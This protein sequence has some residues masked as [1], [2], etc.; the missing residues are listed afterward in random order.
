MASRVGCSCIDHAD[1]AGAL[2]AR[3]HSRRA[4]APMA[5]PIVGGVAEGI[6]RALAHPSSRIRWSRAGPSTWSRVR[7][8]DRRKVS[9]GSNGGWMGEVPL[10][11]GRLLTARGGNPNTGW[12]FTA[13]ARAYSADRQECVP[14]VRRTLSSLGARVLR[15]DAPYIGPHLC[16]AEPLY[17]RL[18]RGSLDPEHRGGTAGTANHPVARL[19]RAQHGCVLDI[20][21]RRERDRMRDGALLGSRLDPARIQAHR[22]RLV[23]RPLAV[24]P[25]RIQRE[26]LRLAEDHRALDHILQ[27]AH[28]PGPRVLSE[29]RE[30]LRGDAEDRLA[31]LAGGEPH[32]VLDERPQISLALAQRRH[33][34]REDGE[35]I[36]E[37]AA[38]TAL[39]DRLSEIAVRS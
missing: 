24:R 6:G 8:A 13:R 10:R 17:A 15:S 32:E 4:V 3:R 27:F 12:T 11:F 33:L 37:V 1:Q 22:L 30:R 16:D 31:D 2:A 5:R 26:C 14:S 19:Q 23:E 39:C 21:E 38:E 29:P 7:H 9:R 25:A 28:I 20:G 18:E 36:E 34:E 35:S